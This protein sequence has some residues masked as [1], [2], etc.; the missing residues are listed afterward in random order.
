MTEPTSAVELAV[1]ARIAKVRAEGERRRQERAELTAARTAGLGQRHAQK[2]RNLA[3][4]Q[5]DTEETAVPAAFRSALCP[6]CRRDQPARCVATVIVSGAPYNV[7][8][9]PDSSC[10]LQWLVRANR[11][12]TSPASTAA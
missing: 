5:P 1:Q 4:A 12:R 7:L 10:E 3:N 11:P 6:S 9:C 8:R 2:L